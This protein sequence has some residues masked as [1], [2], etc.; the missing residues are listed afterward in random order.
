MNPCLIAPLALSIL[1]TSQSTKTS[2]PL[3][4]LISV[5]GS[6]A[7]DVD[8]NVALVSVG[9]H[10][11]AKTAPEAQMKAIETGNNIVAALVKLGISKQSMRT[12]S[13]TVRTVE[14]YG[15][16]KEPAHYAAD[17]ALTVRT[18][19]LSKVGRIVDASIDAGATEVD[20]I[21]FG[22]ISNIHA[23]E[24]ALA[25]AVRNAKAKAL[26]IANALGGTL[27]DIYDVTEAG[28]GFVS[29]RVARLESR[30]PS[31]SILPGPVTVSASVT[32]RYRFLKRAR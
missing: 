15:E 28:G 5:S 30:R 6:G 9:I 13:L 11:E 12:R 10:V 20:G 31:T 23:N 3:P 1:W 17:N 8:P 18:T 24:L 16:S 21:T 29:D 26:A 14:A 27:S 7:I 2:P 4:A 19:D 25:D 22:L 32:I